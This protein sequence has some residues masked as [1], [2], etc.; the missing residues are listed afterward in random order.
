MYQKVHLLLDDMRIVA[1]EGGERCLRCPQMHRIPFR[2]LE[3]PTVIF[4]TKIHEMTA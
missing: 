2:F 4:S 1:A 3:L